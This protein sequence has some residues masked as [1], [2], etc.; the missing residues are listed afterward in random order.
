[1]EEATIVRTDVLGSTSLWE[2]DPVAMQTAL[3]VHDEILRKCLMEHN[4]YEMDTAGDSFHLAFHDPVDAIAFC[5]S[6]TDIEF[7][8]SS[9]KWKR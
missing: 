8:T 2:K 5:F 3:E 7:S 9:V 6:Q 4:G 1:M